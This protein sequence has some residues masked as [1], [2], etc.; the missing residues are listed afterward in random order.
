MPL[1]RSFTISISCTILVGNIL[2]KMA[3]EII[4]NIMT[5]GDYYLN[6]WMPIDIGGKV[7]GKNE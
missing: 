7:G 2:T 6:T 1:I 3:Q 5:G 4:K